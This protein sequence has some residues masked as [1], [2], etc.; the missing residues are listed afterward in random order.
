MT[1]STGPYFAQLVDGDFGK[2]K[3]MVI[4]VKKR[5]APRRERSTAEKEKNVRVT[6]ILPDNTVPGIRLIIDKID[7]GMRRI[8]QRVRLHLAFVVRPPFFTWFLRPQQQQ[9]QQ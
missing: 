8:Q 1:T 5:T 3:F 4:V 6:S 2:S 7:N 9:R